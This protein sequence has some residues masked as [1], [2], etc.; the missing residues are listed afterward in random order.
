MRSLT[1][2]DPE[3]ARPAWLPYWRPQLLA[4]TVAGMTPE[5]AIITEFYNRFAAR[6]AEGMVALY[7]DDVAFRD[8]AFGTLHGDRAKDMWRMLCRSG[9]DLRV[10]ASGIEGA[11]GRGSAHWEADYTFSTRR[12]VHNAVSARFTLRDGLISTHED[13]FDFGAWAQQAFGP[14]GIV[15][16]LP[17]A[18]LAFQVLSRRQLDGWRARRG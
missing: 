10:V 2:H 15:G 17:G 9:T 13:S 1:G 4:P 8:P 11:A 12:T 14:P 16:R 6:D 7:A 5:A 18:S 3:V